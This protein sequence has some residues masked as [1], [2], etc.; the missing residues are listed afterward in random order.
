MPDDD[1]TVIPEGVPVIAAE[2]SD[3]EDNT[4]AAGELD[5]ET[6]ADLLEIVA[7]QAEKDGS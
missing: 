3:D 6:L 4:Q 2:D 7:A 1:P 5:D